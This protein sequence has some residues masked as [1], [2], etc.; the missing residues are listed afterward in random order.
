MLLTKISDYI[1]CKKIYN[2]NT[3][4]INFKYISS[5]SKNIKKNSIFVIDKKIKTTII[6]MM[7]LKKVL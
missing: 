1:N 6:L 3:K 2:L 4:N 7:Q 5:N